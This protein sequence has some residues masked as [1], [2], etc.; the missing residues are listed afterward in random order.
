MSKGPPSPPVDE[1]KRFKDVAARLIAV[2]KSEV[3][4]QEAKHAAEKAGKRKK[5][6]PEG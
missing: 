4:K 2:P 6:Q 3:E 1:F 5:G